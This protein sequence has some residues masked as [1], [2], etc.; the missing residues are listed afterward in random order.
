M[1]ADVEGVTLMVKGLRIEKWKVKVGV[2]GIWVIPAACRSAPKRRSGEFK[3]SLAFLEVQKRSIPGLDT[4][5]QYTCKRINLLLPKHREPFS[6][7]SFD[8]FYHLFLR[9]SFRE[10]LLDEFV[11]RFPFIKV[12]GAWYQAS[13]RQIPELPP[14][15]I[16]SKSLAFMFSFQLS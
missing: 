10:G 2:F 6:L 8:Y 16:C 4:V 14:V 1:I 3:F 7:I 11:H 15:N 9:D 13:G 5:V 12:D